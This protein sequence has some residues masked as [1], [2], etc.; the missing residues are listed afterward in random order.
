MRLENFGSFVAAPWRYP[1]PKIASR[2]PSVAPPV[3]PRRARRSPPMVTQRPFTCNSCSSCP[4]PRA[5]TDRPL[6]QARPGYRATGA[7]N[8][9]GAAIGTA[10]ACATWNIGRAAAAAAACTGVRWAKNRIWTTLKTSPDD[11]LRATYVRAVAQLT[12]V[13]REPGIF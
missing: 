9:T 7:A 6:P 3:T 13:A 11:D 12:R 1:S 4:P 8:I 5:A 10:A 2:A